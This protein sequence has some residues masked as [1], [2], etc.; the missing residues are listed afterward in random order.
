MESNFNFYDL[1]FFGQK[2]DYATDDDEYEEKFQKE[3][4]A[5]FFLAT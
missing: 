2:D 4:L 3:T 1:G 5:L